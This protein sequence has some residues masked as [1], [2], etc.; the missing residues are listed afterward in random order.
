M[1]AHDAID[2]TMLAHDAIDLTMLAHDASWY[3]FSDSGGSPVY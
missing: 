3:V 1:L 2:L